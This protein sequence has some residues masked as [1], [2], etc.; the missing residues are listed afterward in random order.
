MQAATR[1]DPLRE[2]RRQFAE[3]LRPEVYRVA[4]AHRHLLRGRDPAALTTRQ[5]MDFADENPHLFSA[6]GQLER[7]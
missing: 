3:S 7:Q 6:R 4:V 1:I 2:T 5:L